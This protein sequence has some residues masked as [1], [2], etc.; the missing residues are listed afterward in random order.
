[1]KNVVSIESV[2]GDPFKI[3][4]NQNGYYLSNNYTQIPN[5][6]GAYSIM[7]IE[8]LFHELCDRIPESVETL[9]PRGHSNANM[10][11][12]YEDGT[13]VIYTQGEGGKNLAAFTSRAAKYSEFYKN[14]IMGGRSDLITLD[15]L[16]KICS[17][18]IESFDIFI[19]A[20]KDFEEDD[21][22]FLEVKTFPD[23]STSI[24]ESCYGQK[25]KGFVTLLSDGRIMNDGGLRFVRV[26]K[27]RGVRVVNTDPI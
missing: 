23:G 7:E 27:E 5:E 21:Y 26:M 24:D 15:H 13:K 1:M 9:F 12:T 22:L 8:N 2:N 4:R 25:F 10:K 20:L 6:F 11:V 19:K 3:G 17:V 16:R 18:K 14:L